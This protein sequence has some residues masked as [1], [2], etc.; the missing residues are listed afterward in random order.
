MLH[1]IAKKDIL[2]SLESQGLRFQLLSTHDNKG[3]T[4]LFTLL[5]SDLKSALASVTVEQR[6]TLIN[7]RDN[8]GQTVADYHHRRISE[9]QNDM[10]RS[11]AR[12]RL[13][14]IEYCRRE[15]RIQIAMST[16]DDDG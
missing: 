2:D 8:E 7:V 9:E 13:A 14:V 11:L 6:L 16:H 12:A 10:W 15:A 5:P 4:P 1:H 3:L